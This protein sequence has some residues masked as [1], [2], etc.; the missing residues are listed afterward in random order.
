MWLGWFDCDIPPTAKII[1]SEWYYRELRSIW[2][3]TQSSSLENAQPSPAWYRAFLQYLLT[4]KF[5]LLTQKPK[6]LQEQIREIE[7]WLKGEGRLQFKGQPKKLKE[8]IKL[9]AELKL[10]T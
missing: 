3:R 2:E 6:T 1:S 8:L 10:R 7:T 4:N 5:I 9:R